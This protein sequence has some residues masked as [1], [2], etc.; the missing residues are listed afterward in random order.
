MSKPDEP[1]D[2]SS[3]AQSAA[4]ALPSRG[5]GGREHPDPWADDQA[6][7]GPLYVDRHRVVHSAAYSHIFAAMPLRNHVRSPVAML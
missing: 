2:R 6:E 3:D 5:C 1:S 4:Y 7:A